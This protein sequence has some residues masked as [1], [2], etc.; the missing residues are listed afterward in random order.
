MTG[1]TIAHYRILEKL[2][3]GDMGVVYKAVYAALAEG[4]REVRRFPVLS[5]L[6]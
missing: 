3:G 1:E 4:F 6:G 5:K 2:G